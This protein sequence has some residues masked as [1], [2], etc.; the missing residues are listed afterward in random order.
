VDWLRGYDW[1][2]LSTTHFAAWLAVTAWLPFAVAL[3]ID[4]IWSGSERSSLSRLA[5]PSRSA[6]L[7]VAYML[8]T[9]LPGL[10]LFGVITPIAVAQLVFVP[11]IPRDLFP[12]DRLGTGP[13]SVLV[14][15]V[16]VLVLIDLLD[17]WT[18]RTMHRSRILWP[19]HEVHHAATEMTLLTGVRVTLTEQHLIDLV[20]VAVLLL[21]GLSLPAIAIVLIVRSIVD[22]L[23]HSNLA[24]TYG[25]LGYVIASPANHR[26]HHSVEGVDWDTN[27]GNL[28]AVWDHLFGTANPTMRSVNSTATTQRLPGL[29]VPDAVPSAARGV[30][31]WPVLSDVYL[32]S[33]LVRGG[34]RRQRSPDPSI[35]E[36]A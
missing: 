2:A 24:W 8:I 13:L 7:D 34:W 16:V 23:Q 21:L 17:Y 18:H 10:A 36:S 28:L 29:G 15:A 20:R 35:R 14:T 1:S 12:W 31:M 19:F 30:W 26:L 22:A 32:W 25:R 5:K 27:Y 33:R 3:T 11:Y 6:R 4:A 9:D